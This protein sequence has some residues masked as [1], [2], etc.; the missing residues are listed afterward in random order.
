[1][2]PIHQEL[3]YP[4]NDVRWRWIYYVSLL[5]HELGGKLTGSKNVA[6]AWTLETA[7]MCDRNL[8]HDL[9]YNQ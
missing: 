3:R 6:R 5:D 4:D 8:S 7:V 2:C 1:M 9:P